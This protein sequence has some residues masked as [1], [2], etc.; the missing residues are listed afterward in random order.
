MCQEAYSE[1]MKIKKTPKREQ[2]RKLLSL[3]LNKPDEE[4]L[5]AFHFYTACSFMLLK[6]KY[7]PLKAEEFHSLY[8]LDNK[9]NQSN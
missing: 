5:S 9:L 3:L 6:E 1:V 4:Y 8:K 7:Q 2:Q